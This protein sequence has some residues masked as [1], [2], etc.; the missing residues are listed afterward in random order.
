MLHARFEIAKV[1]ALI[2]IT[3]FR[4]SNDPYIVL[5]GIHELRHCL[6]ID[7]AS[8]NMGM[9]NSQILKQRHGDTGRHPWALK[10]P[11]KF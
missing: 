4:Q 2:G 7:G 5:A 6:S 9:S 8:C 3:L 1:R 11:I 10:G